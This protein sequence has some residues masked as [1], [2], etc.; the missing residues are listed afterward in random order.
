MQACSVP[1]AA[2]LC[3]KDQCPER[4]L[5]QGLKAPGGDTTPDGRLGQLPIVPRRAC[6]RQMGYTG[7]PLHGPAHQSTP[8]NT[9][10][11]SMP[12]HRAKWPGRRGRSSLASVSVMLTPSLCHFTD[13]WTMLQLATRH[14]EH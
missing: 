14:L 4:G 10:E 1:R 2:L 7:Q 8:A 13:G 9:R 11:N 3:G 12:P 6:I 5:V